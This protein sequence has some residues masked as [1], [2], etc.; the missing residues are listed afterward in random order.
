MI[1]SLILM[2]T[3]K[4]YQDFGYSYIHE[5]SIAS[6]R[7]RTK[8]AKREYKRKVRR[9]TLPL[10]VEGLEEYQSL[11]AEQEEER[12]DTDDYGDCYCEACL[13]ELFMCAI[14]GCE[15]DSR[16]CEHP[17]FDGVL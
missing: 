15:R 8:N 6:Q 4:N 7:R 12:L 1:P 10:I 13:R 3:P 16:E 17:Q 14:E 9:R 2:R 5:F 11:C